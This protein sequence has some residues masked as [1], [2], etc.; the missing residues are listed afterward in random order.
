MKSINVSV[1]PMFDNDYNFIINDEGEIMLGIS[2]I[3][4]NDDFCYFNKDLPM[5]E[6]ARLLT[7]LN[8]LV[9]DDIII[10]VFGTHH[11]SKELFEM[12]EIF[13]NSN[14]RLEVEHG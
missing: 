7:L 11:G 13:Q 12:W 3:D 14:L 9:S 10:T 6:V 1:V 4:D 5:F 8:I 2:I